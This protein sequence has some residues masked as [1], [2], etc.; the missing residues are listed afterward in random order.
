[1]K[2]INL[3]SSQTYTHR[4]RKEEEGEHMCFSRREVYRNLSSELLP[5]MSGINRKLSAATSCNAYSIK[6]FG[7]GYVG[8]VIMLPNGSQVYTNEDWSLGYRERL[9]MM[10]LPAA[11]REDKLIVTRFSWSISKTQ[12]ETPQNHV[13]TPRPTLYTRCSIVSVRFEVRCRE[14][15]NYKCTLVGNA[16]ANLL[17]L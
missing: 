17:P 1:M 6:S 3:K 14:Q 5:I 4:E 12:F 11:C 9:W 8:A 7:K 2:L 15:M 13:I 16:W 10:I